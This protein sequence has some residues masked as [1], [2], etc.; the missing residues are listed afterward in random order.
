MILI[1]HGQLDGTV[2]ATI[3]RLGSIGRTY[4]Q[5]CVVEALADIESKVDRLREAVG[6]IDIDC[7]SRDEMCFVRAD[8]WVEDIGADLELLEDLAS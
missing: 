7:E 5:R 4:D 3:A 8:E 6:C 1:D 2:E